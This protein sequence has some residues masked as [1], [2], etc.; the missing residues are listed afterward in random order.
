VE[1]G[2]GAVL[3]LQAGL[4]AWLDRLAGLPT[5]LT[6]LLPIGA[7]LC[8]HG[9]AVWIAVGAVL[10]LVNGLAL[11][12]LKWWTEQNRE[13]EVAE[14]QR[15]RVAMK[16]AL[17]PLAALIGA[18]PYQTNSDRQAQLRQAATQTV[19]A[20]VVL[21]P[22]VDRLRA[23]V[24]ALAADDQSMYP[25]AY[26]GRGTAPSPFEAGTVRGDRALT[27]VEQR[28]DALFVEDLD[29]ER[30]EEWEGSGSD[31]KTFISAAISN[32]EFAYGMLTVDAPL[33]GSLGS[34]DADTVMLL[35]DLLAIAFAEA[36]SRTADDQ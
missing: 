14:G 8:F 20:L 6:I 28:G 32:G 22:D 31:Y 26:F 23:V 2:R 10:L 24:F 17:Q 18:M 36:E 3:R 12:G 19:S 25:M 33:A 5:V 11:W 29:K 1:Q 21:M 9:G 4:A 16:D 35:A 15:L 34:S 13:S 7:A 27:L 30:P